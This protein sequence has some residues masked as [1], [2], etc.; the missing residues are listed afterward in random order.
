[1]HHIQ[2]PDFGLAGKQRAESTDARIVAAIGGIQSQH[3]G[4]NSVVF[5]H[6]NKSSRSGAKG[7]HFRDSRGENSFMQHDIFIHVGLPMP[8]IGA[9]R[10]EHEILSQSS[11]KPPNFDQYYQTVCDAELLQEMGRDRALRRGGTI[12]HYW[13]T[14]IELPFTATQMKA[15]ELSRDAASQA[16]KTRM[17]LCNAIAH[18]AKCGKKIT[19]EAIAEIAEVTQGWI[20]KFFARIGGWRKWRKIITGLLNSSNRASNN[21]ESALEGLDE[22]G[23]WIAEVWLRELV[24]AFAENPLGVVEAVGAIVE[25]YGF[26][27]WEQMLALCDRGVVAEL[28]GQM[29]LFMP[30]WMLP[31][32][33][34]EILPRE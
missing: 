2:V 17:G 8:N 23:V 34:Q 32:C 18:L 25:S 29:S 21:S 4:C 6:L 12:F 16:E 30:G 19:Q 20:S 22:A 13:V 28:L 1:V 3:E 31:G 33:L 7:V 14:D 27:V 26:A 11:D 5:D 10:I 15:A 9:V 24:E